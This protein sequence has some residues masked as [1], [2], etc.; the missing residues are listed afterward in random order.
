MAN[1][2]WK[3][4]LPYVLPEVDKCPKAQ[5]V[6]E[7]RR[8]AIDFCQRSQ[9]WHVDLDYLFYPAGVATAHLEPPREARVC[10]VLSVRTLGDQPLEPVENFT[11]TTEAV[12]LVAVPTVDTKMIAHVALKPTLAS[13]GMPEGIMEDW[14]REIAYGAIAALKAM[15]GREWE[16]VPGAQIKN[17]LFEEGIAAAKIRVITGG[18]K[19]SLTVQPRSFF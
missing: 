18:A 5:I 14:G 2:I 4:L 6:H 9:V 19:R 13:T 10:E 1:A 16:D 12:T 3:T 17:E 11:A 15:R 7:I 8:A